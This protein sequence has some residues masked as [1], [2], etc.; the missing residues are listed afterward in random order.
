MKHLTPNT[1][2]N[3]V[4]L[5]AG[6]GGL[7]LGVEQ[8]GF[9]HGAVIEFDEWACKTLSRNR[10]WPI[11]HKDA[12]GFDYC[13]ALKGLPDP[14]Q[15]FRKNQS[16]NGHQF[17]DGARTYKGHTG[18]LYDL[19]AKTLKAGVH[20]VPGGEHVDPSIRQRTLFHSSRMCPPSMLSG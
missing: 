18:S 5:F 9:R 4:E 3:S 13:D 12:R 2:K 14:T 15:P 8:A 6:A 19:P 11:I 20:G 1:T 10:H 16:I 7:A 17:I